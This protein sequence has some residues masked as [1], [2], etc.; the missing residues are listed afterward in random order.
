MIIH[1]NMSI[2]RCETYCVRGREYSRE[3]IELYSELFNKPLKHYLTPYDIGTCIYIIDNTAYENI[4]DERKL[5]IKSYLEME[6]L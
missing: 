4:T 5:T 1:Y 2:K 3:V 6:R